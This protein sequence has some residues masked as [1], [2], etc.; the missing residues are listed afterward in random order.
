MGIRRAFLKGG[1]LMIS[2]KY[3]MEK[4]KRITSL[5]ISLLFLSFGLIVCIRWPILITVFSTYATAVS[6]L[7]LGIVVGVAYN[8]STEVKAQSQTDKE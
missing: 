5:L 2:L 3:M 7:T 1:A 6:T 4:Q 8:R